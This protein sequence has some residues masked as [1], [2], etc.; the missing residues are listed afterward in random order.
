MSDKVEQDDKRR[1]AREGRA[2]RGEDW[3]FGMPIEGDDEDPDNDRFDFDDQEDGMFDIFDMQEM[4]D[5][6]DHR[7][8]MQP[9][10]GHDDG[11]Q[12][13]WDD[14]GDLDPGMFE[15]PPRR[16]RPRRE[17]ELE[18]QRA[19][20]FPPSANTMWQQ[21]ERFDQEFDDR[22]P[23]F[24]AGKR[25]EMENPWPQQMSTAAARPVPRQR[26]HEGGPKSLG[27]TPAVVAR[28]AAL[29]RERRKG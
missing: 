3:H 9:L 26:E 20:V 4:M 18:F 12:D 23:I 14:L 22:A 13:R 28:A 2:L 19:R 25:R 8:G 16:P 17:E 10:H 11:W 29:A 5:M 24:P 7:P 6:M 21:E 1:I 15:A 27:R